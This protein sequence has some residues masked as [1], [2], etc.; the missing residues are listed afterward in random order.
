MKRGLLVLATYAAIG[1][2]GCGEN[3][4][5][6]GASAEANVVAGDGPAV[7]V[8]KRG[9]Y[10]RP[11]SEDYWE[12]IRLEETG[13]DFLLLVHPRIKTPAE[14]PWSA[15]FLDPRGEVF[16]EHHGL[17]VDVATS[18]F[19]FLCQSARFAP[20]DWTLVLEIEKGGLVAGEPKRTYR[21]RLE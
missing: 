12:T 21:F 5:G 15:T 9:Y 6:S 8:V 19:T 20:G 2:S 3:G 7:K 4:N 18:K 14:G 16:S 13:P 1:L 10:P 11:E 17:R